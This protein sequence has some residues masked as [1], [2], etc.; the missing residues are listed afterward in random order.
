MQK[1]AKDRKHSIEIEDEIKVKLA[2]NK[3]KMSQKKSD[4]AEKADGSNSYSL[5]EKLN[6][7]TKLAK[8]KLKL[9]ELALKDRLSNLNLSLAV[10]KHEEKNKDSEHKARKG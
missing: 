7:H 9:M 5:E 8:D 10:E 2:E 1:L 3:I 4:K 6:S